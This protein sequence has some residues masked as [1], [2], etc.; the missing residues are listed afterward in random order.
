MSTF[1]RR[2]DV[3]PSVITYARYKKDDGN[4]NDGNA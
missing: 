2:R 4:K 1:V 3:Q